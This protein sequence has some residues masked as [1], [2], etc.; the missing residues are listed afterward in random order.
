MTI[1]FKH[2]HSTSHVRLYNLWIYGHKQNTN[3]T[4]YSLDLQIPHF[5][6]I[7][8][9]SWCHPCA[10]Q[11]HR[12]THCQDCRRLEIQACNAAR[13]WISAGVSASRSSITE[14]WIRENIRSDA[15]VQKLILLKL[16]FLRL[17]IHEGNLFNLKNCNENWKK[18]HA[19]ESTNIWILQLTNQN[20]LK[21]RVEHSCC[22]NDLNTG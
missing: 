9:S 1:S 7:A 13:S 2:N 8:S 18:C 16:Q 10:G 21:A 14:N 11:T 22:C 17:H 5:R 15:S 6:R 20:K 19:V 4:R 3:I 12:Q